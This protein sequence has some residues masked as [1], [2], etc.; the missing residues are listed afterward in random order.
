MLRPDA[1][2]AFT[3]GEEIGGIGAEELSRNINSV[4]PDTTS[5]LNL[6]LTGLGGKHFFLGKSRNGIQYISEFIKEMDLFKGEYPIPEIVTPFNDSVIFN[7][8]QIDSVVINPLPVLEERP[9]ES[10]L[11][12][13]E[14]KFINGE[15]LDSSI[16]NLANGR[17]DNV[18]TISTD[19]MKFVEQVLVPIFDE[20][21]RCNQW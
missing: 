14:I 18:N 7:K 11:Y 2:I 21:Q 9:R 13:E 3:D 5:I 12:G 8:N 1:N 15:I 20:W 16:I 10:F 6:E 19:D 17:H 4:F